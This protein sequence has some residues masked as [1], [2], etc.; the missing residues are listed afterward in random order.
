MAGDTYYEKGTG[1]EVR[2]REVIIFDTLVWEVNYLDEPP[3]HHMYK[4]ID[5][6]RKF[7]KEKP[8]ETTNKLEMTPELSDLLILVV[9]CDRLHELKRFLKDVPDVTKNKEVLSI[10]N[11]LRA[12]VDTAY[13]KGDALAHDLIK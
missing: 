4:D 11:G 6:E 2:A 1:R 12:I 7:V 9:L 10:V 5:F 8:M 3:V 13:D